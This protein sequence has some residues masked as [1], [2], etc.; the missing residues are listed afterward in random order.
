MRRRLQKF[1]PI[2]LI[3]LAMQVLAP[4]A[5]CWAASLNASDPLRLGEICHSAAASAPDQGDGTGDHRDGA[6]SICCAVHTNTSLDTPQ[7]IVVAPPYR[8]PAS[9]AWLDQMPN[10]SRSAGGSNAQARAPPQTS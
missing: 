8:Q 2:V 9:V 3:A 6:C 10:L 1:L 7:A 5:A 4:I